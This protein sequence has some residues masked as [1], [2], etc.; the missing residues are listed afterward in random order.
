MKTR[1]YIRRKDNHTIT[2]LVILPPNQA[3]TMTVRGPF[4][5][6]RERADDWEKV[7]PIKSDL[8][9]IWRY[10]PAS[11]AWELVRDTYTENAARWL[12]ILQGDEPGATF[13]AS[14]RRPT[15]A[16]KARP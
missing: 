9:N 5:E 15:K 16:P 8:T 13:K 2:G 14:K 4:R 12:D 1:D 11:G 6:M 7:P 10:K 3:G